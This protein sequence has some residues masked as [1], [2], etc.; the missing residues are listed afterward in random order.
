MTIT[1]TA[2]WCWRKYVSASRPIEDVTEGVQHFGVIV[3]HEDAA[4]ARHGTT[5]RS[6]SVRT[7]GRVGAAVGAVNVE[8]H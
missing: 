2:R 5:T 6:R 1:G 3:H 8:C 7:D 4:V